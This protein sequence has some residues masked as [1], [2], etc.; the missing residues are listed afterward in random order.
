M[1][2]KLM[3]QF[4]LGYTR[5]WWIDLFTQGIISQEE[6]LKKLDKLDPQ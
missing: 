5:K 2:E 4:E 3:K 1:F 6:M